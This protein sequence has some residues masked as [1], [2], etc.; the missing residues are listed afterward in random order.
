LFAADL[1]LGAVA[2]PGVPHLLY[3]SHRRL[4]DYDVTPDGQRFLLIPD[5]PREAGALSTALNWQAL[6]R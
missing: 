3:A 1:S 6:L 2:A 4:A 5:S